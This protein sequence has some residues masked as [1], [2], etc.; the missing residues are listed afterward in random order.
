MEESKGLTAF[1]LQQM[2]F[3]RAHQDLASPNY[4]QRT[5]DVL[6]CSLHKDT[7]HAVEV[8]CER[9]WDSRKAN[10]IDNEIHGTIS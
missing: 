2:V 4:T 10:M 9:H 8:T 1:P 5:G 3:W 6:G 7:S